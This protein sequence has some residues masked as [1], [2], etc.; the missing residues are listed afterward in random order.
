MALLYT[1]IPKDHIRLLHLQPGSG[2]AVIEAYLDTV[3]LNA[4]GEY[5]ALS[6]V[7]GKKIKR[8]AIKCN[9]MMVNSTENLAIAIKHLRYPDRPR[10]FWID[11]LCI[12]QQNK[13][14]RSSQVMM[15]GDIYSRAARVVI[16][17]GPADSSSDIAL[18][19]V[20]ITFSDLVRSPDSMRYEMNRELHRRLGVDAVAIERR[21]ARL[22]QTA[23]A[24]EQT[25][26]SS[27][28]DDHWRPLRDVEPQDLWSSACSLLQRDWWTRV[29]IIQELCLSK[30]AVVVCGHSSAPWEA[31]TFAVARFDYLD[32]DESW[33]ELPL[34]ALSRYRSLSTTRVNLQ[35]GSVRPGLLDALVRFRW[36]RATDQVDKVYALLSMTDNS[37]VTSDYSLGPKACFEAVARHIIEESD[38]LDILDHVVPPCPLASRQTLDLASWAPDW[39]QNGVSNQ[40][41]RGAPEMGVTPLFDTDLDEDPRKEE[42]ILTSQARFTGAGLLALRG[43][44]ID[45]VDHVH[46]IIRVPSAGLYPGS[47]MIS[48]NRS[49]RYLSV[50]RFV[51]QL[52]F[53]LPVL[54]YRMS[55][56]IAYYRSLEDFAGLATTTDPDIP[57]DARSQSANRLLGISMSAGT[58]NPTAQDVQEFL[59]AQQDLPEPAWIRFL[60]FLQLHKLLPWLYHSLYGSWLLYLSA[61]D[62]DDEDDSIDRGYGPDGIASKACQ[63]P[64]VTR[65]GYLCFVPH[66]CVV[67]DRVALLRG[68]R[69]PY[70]VR[71]A[72][73]ACGHWGVVGPCYFSDKHAKELKALWSDEEAMEMM[74]A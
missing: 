2:K 57:S 46:G 26:P 30:A 33:A 27:A 16:W 72:G 58:G 49:R 44:V 29:W 36:F 40:Y 11:A 54:S 67:G 45:R 20:N 41:F 48:P 62:D 1:S 64:A 6:Y 34:A 52:L 5:E 18:A 12:D 69:R 7:W 70:V 55:T 28:I 9:G 63:R 31:M 37:G 50:T 8:R 32:E 22:A 24:A 21:L 56:L 14:E 23:E 60:R 39:G 68:G 35:A 13:D 47:P 19:Y 73:G 25:S 53:Q 51:A 3:P 61:T 74:F 4:A 15:M 10:I 65:G 38:N 59:D 43:I 66:T 42:P 71:D 17:L